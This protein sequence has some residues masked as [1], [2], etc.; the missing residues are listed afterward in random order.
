MTATIDTRCF[1]D[2][3]EL[4]RAE[5]ARLDLRIRL[6]CKTATVD[7]GPST[8]GQL[9]RAM[10]MAAGE[11][12][13]VLATG[14]DRAPDQNPDDDAVAEL[15]AHLADISAEIDARTTASAQCGIDL[16]LPRLGRLFGLTPMELQSL[17]VCLAPELRAKYDRLYAQLQDDIT[18]RRPSADLVLQLLCDSETERWSATQ[19]LHDSSTL[20]RWELL[21]T[22]HDPL[23]PSGSS[24]LA[25]FLTVD[26]RITQFLLG[27]S[28]CDAR[29]DTVAA[30]LDGDADPP[31]A[32]PDLEA[33]AN[34]LW[35]WAARADDCPQPVA[36]PVI[37]LRGAAGIGTLDVARY[38]CGAAAVPM[39]AVDTAALLAAGPDDITTLMRVLCREA[40]LQ[41]CALYLDGADALLGDT[42]RRAFNALRA[43]AAD[44]RRPLILAGEAFWS[45]PGAF[46]HA[47]FRQLTVGHPD[48]HSRRALW[49]RQLAADEPDDG[50]WSDTLASRFVLSAG[51]IRNAAQIARQAPDGTGAGLTLD[52]LKAACRAESDQ[53]LGQLAAKVEIRRGWDDLVLPEAK[54]AQLREICQQIRHRHVVY[55]D[56]GYSQR[57]GHGTGVTVLFSGEPGTGKTVAA[58]VIAGDASLPLYKID[59]SGVVS[60]Y[61]GE[62]EKNLAKIFERARA[63]NAVLFFDEADALFGKRTEVSDAH[64]RYA[65]I[66]TSY[67]LQKLEEHDGVVILASNLRANLDD[68]FT[69]RIR[70]VVEFPFPDE[71]ARRRIWQSHFPLQAPL[72]DD[73]DVDYL[74]RAF[75]VAGGNISNIVVG[76]AFLAAA[77]DTTIAAQHI[78]ASTRREYDKLGKLWTPPTQPGVRR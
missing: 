7:E 71:A 31:T 68:A 19:M 1:L 33:T 63:G 70:C 41:R 27:D 60:K 30:L 59:L 74:A 76:A 56:W 34:L 18:R 78:V 39:L 51:Q 23:S 13:A 47:V 29:L 9:A 62:T 26:P 3:Y 40:L 52:A 10:Y 66:E 46:G 45:A 32:D 4:L 22:S 73:V 72:A 5:L 21:R 37:Y 25:Q 15:G 50:S 75:P 24:R 77:D 69:R 2:D 11:Q 58:Q 35:A 36:A 61:I 53:D 49:R 64:D 57:L 8:S 44:A 17:V 42:A 6:R 43:A 54:I 38:L 48:V 55:G 20:M 67:L 16:S 14:L 65:N 28:R 12:A